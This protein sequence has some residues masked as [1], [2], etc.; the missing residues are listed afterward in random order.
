[1]FNMPKIIDITRQRA[2]YKSIV[3]VGSTSINHAGFPWISIGV[4][5][6]RMDPIDEGS[7]ARDTAIT[8]TP[9]FVRFSCLLLAVPPVSL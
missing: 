7:V 6:T 3:L 4:A 8:H 2:S 9:E 5:A 1:M